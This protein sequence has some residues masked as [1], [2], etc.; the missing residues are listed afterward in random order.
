MRNQLLT[1]SP[2]DFKDISTNYSF[3]HKKIMAFLVNLQSW[4]TEEYIT[5]NNLVQIIGHHSWSPL[6]IVF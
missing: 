1:K 5:I 2:I 3:F 4:S 6:D